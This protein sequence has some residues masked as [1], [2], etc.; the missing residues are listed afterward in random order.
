MANSICP[1]SANSLATE[2]ARQFRDAARVRYFLEGSENTQGDVTVS[3]CVG[4]CRLGSALNWAL[5]T[6]YMRCTWVY[7]QLER[8]SA[9]KAEK[10]RKAIADRKI[11]SA[12]SLERMEA[13][14]ARVTAYDKITKVCSAVPLV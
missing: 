12:R 10:R 4:L 11:H 14:A 3:A 7:V 13:T 5:T 6:M 1:R 9:A 2:F 8:R